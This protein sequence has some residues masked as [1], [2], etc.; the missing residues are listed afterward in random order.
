VIFDLPNRTLE[1]AQ[2]VLREANPEILEI[3]P[4]DE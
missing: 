1:R 4:Q 2:P 3:R